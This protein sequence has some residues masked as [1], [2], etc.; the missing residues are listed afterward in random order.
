MILLIVSVLILINYLE[1][2][3]KILYRSDISL[4]RW[5]EYLL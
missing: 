3:E 4:V 1:G 2:V 5:E